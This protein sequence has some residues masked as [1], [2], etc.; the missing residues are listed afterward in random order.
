[1]LRRLLAAAPATEAGHEV[2]YYPS[3]YPQEIRIEPLDP[4]AA[5]KEFLSKTAPLN[6]YLG[7]SPRF[8]GR[9]RA[10]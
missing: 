2:P 7:A 4:G 3:F 6:L 1:V 9:R 10:S 8:D 5:A